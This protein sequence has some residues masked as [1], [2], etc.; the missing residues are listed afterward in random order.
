MIAAASLAQAQSVVGK[1]VAVSDGDTLTLLIDKQQH[2]IRMAGIDA[3]ESKQDFG[4]KAKEDLSML[5]FGKVVAVE[6]TKTDKYGRLVRK[7]LVEGVD[8]NLAQIRAGLAWHYKEYEKEQ[9]KAD[10]DAYAAAEKE[11]RN[12]TIGLWSMP[13]P[14]RPAEFRHGPSVAEDLKSK[15]IGNKNS[16]IYHWF[17]CQGFTKVSEKNRVLF[18]TVKD[19]ET[20][21]YKAA[22]NCSPP[23]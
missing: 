4:R 19:A 23:R 13:N 14:R 5:V 7:V 15:I 18:A 9:T 12:A 1:V 20:S 21:G 8:A 3:P 6:G 22:K 10:R 11:A 16:R 17:G 2:K